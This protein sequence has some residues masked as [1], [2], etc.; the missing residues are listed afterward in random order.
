MLD[1]CP[2][3]IFLVKITIKLI[4]TG[5]ISNMKLFYKLKDIIFIGSNKCILVRTNSITDLTI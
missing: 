1:R 5:I 4:K 2:L 3:I